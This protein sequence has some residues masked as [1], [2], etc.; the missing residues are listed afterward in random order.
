MTG[1]SVPVARTL[2][3]IGAAVDRAEPVGH[4]GGAAAAR[5]PDEQAR[6][7]GKERCDDRREK[8]TPH[9]IL[10]AESAEGLFS[11]IFAARAS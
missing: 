11:L 6:C 9:E 10:A 7:A 3:V 8:K 1:F 2:A 4:V 5:A